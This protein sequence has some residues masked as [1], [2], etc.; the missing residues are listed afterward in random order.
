MDIFFTIFIY[1]EN[2]ITKYGL[3]AS[4]FGLNIPRILMKNY[5]NDFNEIMNFCLTQPK[6]EL[7]F[8]NNNI[9][10]NKMIPTS[11]TPLKK[12]GLVENKNDIVNI[13]QEANNKCMQCE[14]ILC[15]NENEIMDDFLEK[16]T[17]FTYNN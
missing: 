14:E 1:E 15:L 13:K 7:K 9:K 3:E 8:I 4:S 10:E 6:D 5:S 11:R 12:V 16:L 17:N 2:I